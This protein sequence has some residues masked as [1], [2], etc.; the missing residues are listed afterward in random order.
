M[1][2]LQE[3][4]KRS[5]K[6]NKH[7]DS[8]SLYNGVK[9]ALCINRGLKPIHIKV[10]ETAELYKIIKVN[11]YMNFRIDHDKLRNQWPHPAYSA[12]FIDEDNTQEIPTNINIYTDGSKSEQG[13]GAGIAIVSQGKTTAEIMFK[14]D[15]RCTN[16]ICRHSQYS[17]RWKTYKPNWKTT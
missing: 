17:R 1:G 3:N 11:S 14:M 6:A 15:T 2:A 10:K 16:K 13:V 4:V 12:I 7:N 5:T 8:K 9:R